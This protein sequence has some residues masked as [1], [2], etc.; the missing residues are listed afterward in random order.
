MFPVL[1]GGP[2][3]TFPG[4]GPLSPDGHSCP[5]PDPHALP[6]LVRVHLNIQGWSSGQAS[7]VVC[8]VQ[9]QQFCHHL[10]LNPLSLGAHPKVLPPEAGSCHS[11]SVSPAQIV[12]A[13]AYPCASGSWHLPESGLVLPQGAGAASRPCCLSTCLHDAL[14]EHGVV[15]HVGMLGRLQ[16][17]ERE[18]E[19]A[20]AGH[21]GFTLGPLEGH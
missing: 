5:R 10:L 17:A 15:L 13:P 19:R 9:R 12:P 20:A 11:Q 1:P 16:P 7:R 3:G 21:V 8:S 4:S 14:E 2:A 18:E 6:I